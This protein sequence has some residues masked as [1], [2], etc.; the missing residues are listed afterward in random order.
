VI[1]ASSL[2]ALPAT[3]A[4]FIQAPW[5]KSLAAFFDYS[6]PWYTVIYAALIFGFT[7]FYTSMVFNPVE[8]ADNIRKY[9]GFIPGVRAGRPT[10]DMLGRV[11]NRI[12][13]VGALFLALIAILPSFMMQLTGLSGFQALSGTAMLIVIGVALETM[14]QIEAQLVMRHYD[15][16]LK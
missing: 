10:A 16:F 3:L 2:L 9:G 12:T 6:Q 11:V 8:V 1:F 7:F 13:F 4:T 15:G 5:A 14:K